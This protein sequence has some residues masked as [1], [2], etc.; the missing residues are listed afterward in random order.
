MVGFSFVPGEPRRYPLGLIAMPLRSEIRQEVIDY[1]M[2]DIVPKSAG[3]SAEPMEY[4][5]S[6]FR[7]IPDANLVVHLAEAFYQARYIGRVRESLAL[8]SGFNHAFCKYQIVLYASI[9]EAMIDY[10]LEVE[11]GNEAVTTMLTVP[12]LKKVTAMSK[13]AKI[14]FTQSGVVHNVVMAKE[15][16]MKLKL[17]DIRFADRV[18]AGASIG[19]VPKS[20]ASFIKK[21]Y[22]SRNNIHLKSSANNSFSPDDRQSSAAFKKLYAFIKKSREWYAKRG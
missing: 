10:F 16:T 3:W 13:N 4:F 15:S 20:D 2:R 5:Q 9:Y 19:F 17:R 7:F 8:K 21:L 14:E 18:D 1:V 6:Q 22:T 12:I 11:S